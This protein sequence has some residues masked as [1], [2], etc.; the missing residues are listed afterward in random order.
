MICRQKL[1]AGVVL[2]VFVNTCLGAVLW[3][4]R[5]AQSH[6]VEEY[7]EQG[8]FFCK[9]PFPPAADK[10]CARPSTRNKRNVNCSD[11]SPQLQE[12]RSARVS[13]ESNLYN[14]LCRNS[15]GDS[16]D[17]QAAIRCLIPLMAPNHHHLAEQAIARYTRLYSE[18]KGKTDWMFAHGEGELRFV[19]AISRPIVYNPGE[20]TTGTRYLRELL[21]TQHGFKSMAM[22]NWADLQNLTSVDT[23]TSFDSFVDTPAAAVFNYMLHVAPKAFYVL[24]VREAPVWVWRRLDFGKKQ[25]A[26]YGWDLT[27]PCGTNPDN[28]NNLNPN[29]L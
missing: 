8:E 27:N 24:T 6:T 21:E 17:T 1:K 26:T 3:Y 5:G 13:P 2:V 12:L 18:C 9:P 23:E 25:A 7:E 15:C 14:I 10:S 19:G 4:R 28:L 22:E 20:G 29:N 11:P 16:R